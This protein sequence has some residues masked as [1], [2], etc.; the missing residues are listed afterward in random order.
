M[1]RGKL[2]S[3][4]S[5]HTVRSGGAQVAITKQTECRHS[6]FGLSTPRRMIL[7]SHHQDLLSSIHV[8]S[9]T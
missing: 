5:T 8:P 3:K 2:A 4:D 1:D 6:A 7:P 9:H